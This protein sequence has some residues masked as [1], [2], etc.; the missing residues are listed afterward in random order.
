[1]KLKS[2]LIFGGMMSAA[3]SQAFG[4]ADITTWA[5]AGSNQAAFV[6]DWNDGVTPESLVWGFRWEG[7]ATGLDMINGIMAVDPK[8]S[9]VIGGGGPNTIFGLGYDTDGDGLPLTGSGEFKVPAD[10]G[11]HYREGWF[12]A[13]FWGYYVGSGE[14]I[15]A[16]GFGGGSFISASLTNQDWHGLSYAPGFN[17]DAPSVPSNPVPE[18]ATLA[19]V[20]LGALA[21]L[22]RRKNRA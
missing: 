1:M 19:A 22:R 3:L 17:G 21:L 20:G 13:G 15:P 16:W 4:L 9:R 10:P 11:D 7:S 5:G 14:Q 6:V 8:L 12:S 2:I 18:P